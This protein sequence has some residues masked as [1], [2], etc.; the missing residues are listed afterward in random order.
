MPEA[1]KWQMFQSST[2]LGVANIFYKSSNVKNAKTLKEILHKADV[3]G[4]EQKAVLL[5][6]PTWQYPTRLGL[7][8][9]RQVAKIWILL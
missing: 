5:E 1:L 2:E 7:Q 3:V 8:E 6:E 9:I 4:K